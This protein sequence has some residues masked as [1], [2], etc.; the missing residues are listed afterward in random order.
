MTE[1]ERAGSTSVISSPSKSLPPSK[2]NFGEDDPDLALA[3]IL[4]EQERAYFMLS[5][6]SGGYDGAGEGDGVRQLLWDGEGSREEA[7]EDEGPL[8]DEQ[9]ALR[10]QLELQALGNVVGTVSKGL[11]EEVLNQLPTKSYQDLR[12]A[13]GAADSD[14]PDRAGHEQ[15]MP[16]LRR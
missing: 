12:D 8:D 6:G 7:D 15:D 2:L 11:T 16:Q 13:N 5:Q 4:Q 14:D 10:M 9:L 1:T 3:R